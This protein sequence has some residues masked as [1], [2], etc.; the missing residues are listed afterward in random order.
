MIVPSFESYDRGCVA[1]LAQDGVTAPRVA[2]VKPGLSSYGVV[3]WRRH[4][5]T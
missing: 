3:P 1:K 5:T 2:C 4:P